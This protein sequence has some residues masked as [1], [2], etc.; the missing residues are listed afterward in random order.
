M[1]KRLKILL[2]VIAALFILAA[3]SFIAFQAFIHT[4]YFEYDDIYGTG[5]W[6]NDDEY[7]EYERLLSE[8]Y[9]ISHPRFRNKTPW[10]EEAA[11]AVYSAVNKY[12]FDYAS[13]IAETYKNYA[14]LDYTVTVKENETLT[15]AFTGTGYFYDESEPVSLD[16]TFVFN[17]RNASA[18][19][20]PTL[21]N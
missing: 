16:K 14:R 17:I 11:K 19:N 8:G 13:E 15:V 6:T 2:T 7:N 20:P 9:E 18:G 4:I 10:G 21:I 12:M 3:A 1:T 5:C